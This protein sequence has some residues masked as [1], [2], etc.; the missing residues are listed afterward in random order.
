MSLSLPQRLP[1]APQYR[2]EWQG[3]RSINGAEATPGL[4]LR[5]PAGLGRLARDGRS[6]WR[7][8][9][10]AMGLPNLIVPVVGEIIP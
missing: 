10:G 2:A 6:A 9:Q 7:I 1:L 3:G 8:V 5:M 4:G